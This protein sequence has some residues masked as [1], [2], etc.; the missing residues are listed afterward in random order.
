[1][2]YTFFT[3][4]WRFPTNNKDWTEQVKQDL[5]DLDISSDLSYIKS[6]SKFSFTNMVKRKAKKYALMQQ[7]EQKSRHSKMDNLYYCEPQM[8]QYLKSNKFTTIQARTIFSF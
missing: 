6:K 5:I 4:Q 8:Q 1:M 2:S 7:M 3:T